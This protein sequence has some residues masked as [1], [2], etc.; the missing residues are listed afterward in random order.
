MLQFPPVR[1]DIGV[2]KKLNK[3]ILPLCPDGVV[4]LGGLRRCPSG[5]LAGHSPGTVV[6]AELGV[7]GMLGG[8]SGKLVLGKSGMRTAKMQ[9]LM[10]GFRMLKH[11]RG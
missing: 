9:M 3:G 2:Q 11:T 6:F 5:C 7:E 4:D 1:H 10:G 8:P